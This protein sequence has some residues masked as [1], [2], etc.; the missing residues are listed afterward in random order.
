MAQPL[1]RKNVW[2][3]QADTKRRVR[4]EERK[5]NLP[6]PYIYVGDFDTLVP[7]VA[8]W[9]S[10]AWQNS[11]TWVGTRYVGFRHGL[12]GD[13]EFIGQLDLTQGA[14]TGTVAFT[15]PLPWCGVSFEFPFPIFIGGNDWINGICSVDATPGP[16]LGDVTIYWPVQATPI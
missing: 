12:D 5:P 10:P 2:I 4:H 15:L 3:R 7:S 11:F 14:V 9:Q 16:T 1:T 6:G 13:V 8:T